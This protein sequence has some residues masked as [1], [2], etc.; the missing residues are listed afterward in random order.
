MAILR[1]PI[2][3]T[4]ASF[5]FQ[6]QLDATILEYEFHYNGR[7]ERWFMTVRDTAGNDILTGRPVNINLDMLG[8]FPGLEDLPDGLMVPINLV[9]E[10]VEADFET[11]GE[12]VL[13]LYQE[14]TG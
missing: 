10:F 4:L 11:F 6:T 1:M 9:S 3:A 14:A 7:Q 13:M 2:D 12:D 5:R 8:R